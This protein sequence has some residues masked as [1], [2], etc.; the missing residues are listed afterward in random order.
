MTDPLE[1]SIFR[2]DVTN[3]KVR[4]Y[5]KNA[6]RGLEFME[7]RLIWAETIGITPTLRKLNYKHAVICSV[8]D[9]AL[10]MLIS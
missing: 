5:P 3:D 1:P 9:S 8:E 2:E 6:R 7:N 4:L 10:N